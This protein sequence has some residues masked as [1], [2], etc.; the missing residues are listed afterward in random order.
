MVSMVS[1]AGWWSKARQWAAAHPNATLA[2]LVLAC[3]GPFIAKPFNMDDPLFVWTARQIHAHP[4]NPYGFNVN[5]YGSPST[6]W[7]VLQNPPLAAYYLALAAAFLGWS[8]AALHG[9]MLLPALAVILGTHRLARRCGAPPLTAALATLFTPVFLVSSI[10]VMCD[11]LLLAFWVWAVVLWME[12]L[13]RNAFWLLAGAGLLMALAVWTKYFGIALVPLLAVY[14][15]MVRRKAGWW[16]AALLVPVL[17]VC[18]WQWATRVLYHQAHFSEAVQ[19]ADNLSGF[20][21]SA[22]ADN[23]LTTLT[24]TGGCVATVVF[25]APWLWRARMLLVTAVVATLLSLAVISQGTLLHLFEK[26]PSWVKAPPSFKLSLETQIVFWAVGGILTLALAVEDVWRRRD[27]RAWLLGLWVMGTFVFTALFNWTVNGRSIL[28]M[29]PAVGILL[30]RRWEQRSMNPATSQRRLAISLACAAL[31]ALLVTQADYRFAVC[32]RGSAEAIGERFGHNGHKLWFQG[33]W[34]FQ[35]YMME[36]GATP[37]EIGQS[38]VQPGDV[39]AIPFDNCNVHYPGSPPG[40]FAIEG[41][42]FVIAENVYAGAAFYS[43][44]AG[45]LPFSFSHAPDEITGIYY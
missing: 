2:L 18:G 26:M 22:K 11:T 17:A 10:T 14:G 36:Q 40:R 38:V 23:L 45:P 5:W 24:F 35:Y 20:F 21:S 15:G 44:V 34:G 13:I 12:G 42:H 28:P 39:L 37:E 6:M 4:L 8:E 7:A 3:L 30:A 43:S 19:Y 33:H 41:P 9:A 32:A 29:A 31:L 16:A 25:L 27:A 1:Y